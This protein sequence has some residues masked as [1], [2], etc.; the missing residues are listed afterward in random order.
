MGCY[1]LVV[2]HSNILDSGYFMISFLKK[3]RLKTL[4]FNLCWPSWQISIH[5][6]WWILVI[7]DVW[8]HLGRQT[9]WTE[10]PLEL[11]L[12]AQKLSWES[13]DDSG[14]KWLAWTTKV[15]RTCVEESVFRKSC[16]VWQGLSYKSCVA[17]THS[18]IYVIGQ[19]LYIDYY[20]LS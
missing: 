20:V 11:L 2:T 7:Y 15:K 18:G 19:W 5:S 8:K 14:W 12:Q 9:I 1:T 4:Q 10:T 16:N 3:T 13:E 17:S 6:S